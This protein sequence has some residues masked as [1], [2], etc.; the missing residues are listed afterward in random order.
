MVG[1]GEVSTF[2]TRCAGLPIEER[3]IYFD[4]RRLCAIDHV[5]RPNRDIAAVARGHLM[6]HTHPGEASRADLRARHVIDR[7]RISLATLYFSQV[8]P[9]IQ[10]ASMPALVV[11]NV[12]T[13]RTLRR[14]PY[15]PAIEV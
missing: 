8:L 6:Q 2:R 1:V 3:R 9:V 13:E 10:G 14:G 15:R 12:R 4:H 5:E 7:D 11:K